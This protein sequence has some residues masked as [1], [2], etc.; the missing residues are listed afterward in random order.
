[1]NL[2]PAVK[3]IKLSD[4]MAETQQQADEKALNK[5]SRQ[6]AALGIYPIQ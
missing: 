3:K 6:N 2:G 1:M 5:F 4:N